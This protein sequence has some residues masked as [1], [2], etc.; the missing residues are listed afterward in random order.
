MDKRYLTKSRFKLAMECPTK[1]YYTGKPGYANQNQSNSFL[2][3]LAEG[4]YQVGALAKAYFPEGVEIETLDTDQSYGQTEKL[5]E[6]E[7]V[8]IFEAGFRVRN[9]FVRADIVRKQGSHLELIEVKSKSSDRNGIRNMLNKNGSIKAEW[10][11][12]ILDIAFQKLVILHSYPELTVNAS[13]MT[14][15]QSTVCPTDGLN[16]KFKI[17]TNPA[18]AKQVIQTA[19]L[20]EE[21]IKN[22]ILRIDPVDDLCEI[23]Y[24]DAYSTP[25]GNLSFTELVNYLASHYAE[26]EKII[27]PISPACTKCEFKSTAEE[28][29]QGLVSGFEICWTQQLGWSNDDFREPMVFDLWNSRRISRYLAEGKFKLKDLG[30]NDLDPKSDSKPGISSSERQWLQV[31]KVKNQDAG[32]WIDKAGLTREF[33]SWTFPLHFIDFETSMTAIPFNRGKR[34]YEPIAFQYSHHIVH[35]DGSIEHASEYLNTKPGVFPNFDFVR[36]LKRDLEGDSGTIFRYAPHENTYLQLIRKQLLDDPDPAKDTTELCRFIDSMTSKRGDYTGDRNMIDMLELVKRYYYDPAMNGSNSIK[37]VLPALLN[38]SKVLQDKYSKPIYGRSD[39]I[40]SHNYKDKVWIE[41]CDGQVK[42]P[43]KLLRR[44]FE[45]WPDD[46][47]ERI[48]SLE[49]IQE[50]GAAAIAYARLQ[51]EEMGDYERHEIERSLLEYCELDTLAMVMIYEG[52]KA[53]IDA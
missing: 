51:S 10:K 5:F 35:E 40:Y 48:S 21:E 33:D 9:L 2:E 7:Q 50:G 45:D 49:A 16:Q 41:R 30:P 13:I 26:D 43:Y 18:G 28:A 46:N 42:D 37:K 19:S 15:D 32:C 38:S 34:P 14:V 27:T 53:L 1:L 20:T 24:S 25:S 17:V 6:Q 3:S 4:G 8:T 22:P 47:V 52:W 29:S 39:G 44:L 36:S 11:P 12:Y 31:E 23:I